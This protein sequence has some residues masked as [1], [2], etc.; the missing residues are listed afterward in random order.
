MLI[1]G[2]ITRN[3]FEKKVNLCWMREHSGHEREA[4]QS[5]K[6]LSCKPNARADGPLGS[7]PDSQPCLGSSPGYEVQKRFPAQNHRMVVDQPTGLIHCFLVVPKVSNF[8]QQ[9]LPLP[10]AVSVRTQ[11]NELGKLENIPTQK[12]KSAKPPCKVIMSE[13]CFSNKR[14][15]KSGSYAFMM[16]K[17]HRRAQPHCTFSLFV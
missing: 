12:S 17:R 13:I 14:L 8:L 16:K 9:E 2:A 5:L 1:K 6:C 3:F 4:T 11:N 7:W 15:T 10:Q